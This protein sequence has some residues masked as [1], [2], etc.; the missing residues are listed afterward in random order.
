MQGKKYLTLLLLGLL[1][2]VG[3]HNGE[4]SNS[5]GSQSSDGGQSSYFEEEQT[6]DIDIDG[7]KDSVFDTSPVIT[8]GVEN[9]AQ[10]QFFYGEKGFNFYAYVEDDTDYAEND[11]TWQN[12]SI[13]LYID[14]LVDGQDLDGF[15]KIDDMQ[16]RMDT[17][18]RTE[19]YFG[20]RA[21]DYYWSATYFS[22]S[23]IVIRN[24]DHYIIEGALAWYNF[25]L[26]S[27][28]EQM[29][30][31][32]GHVDADSLGFTWG[33]MEGED[34]TNPTTWGIY[35][36]M[37]NK[38]TINYFPEQLFSNAVIFTQDNNEF[39]QVDVDFGETALSLRIHR[40]LKTPLAGNND[41]WWDGS[42]VT[43][44]IDVGGNGG[45][46]LDND[47]LKLVIR[48]S[49]DYAAAIGP[50]S[51]N[52]WGMWSPGSWARNGVRN[53]KVEVD[54]NGNV[55]GEVPTQPYYTYIRIP[56][57]D[58]AIEK[59][60]NIR[61]FPFAGSERNPS[62]WK[63]IGADGTLTEEEDAP[64]H[65]FDLLS[66]AYVSSYEH[67]RY[68]NFKFAQDEHF[69]YFSVTKEITS[70]TPTA[71]F[72]SDPNLSYF[73]LDTKG[74]KAATPQ[75]D[76]I[77]VFFQTN[78][79]LGATLGNGTTFNDP[80]LEGSW[81]IN[82]VPGLYLETRL[83]DYAAHGIMVVRVAISKSLVNIEGAVSAIGMYDYSNAQK[84]EKPDQYRTFN[85]QEGQFVD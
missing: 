11:A 70:D 43:A 46:E 42:Q 77:K 69:I 38:I 53:I 24:D 85:Y 81:A 4:T 34:N 58:L 27:A 63:F 3:C 2:L 8:F 12:D 33:G 22:L 80:W 67:S 51:E 75:N 41:V 10:I 14:P 37:G 18:G 32:F 52:G 15:P 78:G 35:D 25:E 30:I 73:I 56:Y 5:K 6:T 72:W 26:A 29:A 40:N 31:N 60:D 50:G 21:H 45:N 9:R 48:P 55:A 19:F 1:S 66:A 59:P 7:V 74:D 83:D 82:S 28:P 68:R 17:S 54:L 20:K 44:I 61:L 64:K 16:I 39:P 13:E 49:G 79:Y 71:N 47:D 84:E 65:N 57:H 62:T 76:D 23:H 36:A